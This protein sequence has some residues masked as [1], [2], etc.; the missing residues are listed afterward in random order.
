MD[1][2]PGYHL[3]IPAEQP[4][5]PCTHRPTLGMDP[6]E[7]TATSPP[8]RCPQG[9]FF[10]GNAAL[11]G[12]HCPQQLPAMPGLFIGPRPQAGPRGGEHRVHGAGQR[13]FLTVPS[14][15]LARARKA[16]S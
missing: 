4:A 5:V 16:Q 10:L 8:P 6:L 12:S 14:W 3:G 9:L 13:L 15:P 1:T 7:H 2:K 11:G